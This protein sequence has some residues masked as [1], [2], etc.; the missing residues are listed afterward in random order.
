MLYTHNAMDKMIEAAQS[1][2]VNFRAPGPMIHFWALKM[3][4][5]FKH[6]TLATCTHVADMRLINQ[7]M[8]KLKVALK[9]KYKMT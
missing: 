9:E 4:H 5:K 8:H 6:R 3:L 1:H 2:P 7:V